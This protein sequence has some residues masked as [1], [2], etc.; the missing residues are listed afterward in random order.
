MYDKKM[1]LLA[2][3]LGIVASIMMLVIE[4]DVLIRGNDLFINQLLPGQ[5]LL[6]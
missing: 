3:I 2:S 1:T 6:D 4:G 5:A